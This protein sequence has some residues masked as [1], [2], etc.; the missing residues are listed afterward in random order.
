[1]SLR[2]DGALRVLRQDPPWKVIRAFGTLVHLHNVSGGILAGDRLSLDVDA[3][4]PMVITTTDATRLYRH[5]AGAADSEQHLN[6][7]IGEGAM[8]EYLPDPL[9]PYAG[10][11]HKQQAR[12][13]LGPGAT[14]VWWEVLAKT[15]AFERLQISTA[16]DV[17]GKPALR[18]DFLLEPSKRPLTSLARMGNA[19]HLTSF[20]VFSE[21]KTSAFWSMMADELRRIAPENWGVSTLATGVVSRGL[22]SR[23]HPKVLD[24]IRNAASLLLTG[25]AAVP[26]RKVY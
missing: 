4:A 11:R 17:C 5:R 26:P 1:L 19:T 22:S 10:S 2:F 20:N 14:L 16:I 3:A 9:I 18:E 21:G 24:T 25:N 12:F 13:S 23:H 7:S 15:S 8:L 6:F